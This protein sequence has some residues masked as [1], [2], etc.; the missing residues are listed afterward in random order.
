[1]AGFRIG[2]VSRHCDQPTAAQDLAPRW[3]AEPL[4]WHPDGLG[5]T[6]RRPVGIVGSDVGAIDVTHLESRF[7]GG[8]NSEPGPCD[9]GLCRGGEVSG[10]EALQ[11]ATVDEELNGLLAVPPTCHSLPRLPFI[12]SF[13]ANGADCR[14]GRLVPQQLPISVGGTS[15]R[16]TGP[17]GARTI[18]TLRRCS[19]GASRAPCGPARVLLAEETAPHAMAAGRSTAWPGGQSGRRRPTSGR[20]GCV[21]LR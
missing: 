2:I 14:F 16:P 8:L 10:L 12:R 4:R 13:G 7:G 17:E 3:L 1:M 9:Q 19:A 6:Q 21:A 15:D 18:M 20:H 11:A 5:A